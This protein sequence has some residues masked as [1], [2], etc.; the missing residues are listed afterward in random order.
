MEQ[1]QHDPRDSEEGW[2]YA[3][4]VTE[5]PVAARTL[6]IVLQYSGFF[7]PVRASPERAAVDAVNDHRS[8]QQQ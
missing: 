7:A 4:F 1:H 3:K 6:E 2:S 8:V 5:N